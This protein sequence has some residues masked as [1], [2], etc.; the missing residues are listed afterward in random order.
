MKL[1]TAREYRMTARADAAARTGERILEAA[2]ELFWEAPTT[3]ISLAAVAA[4]AGGAARTG[5]RRSGC[6]ARKQKRR[7]PLCSRWRCGWRR[8]RGCRCWTWM[9]ARVR[10]ESWLYWI[11]IDSVSF[12]LYAAQRLSFVALLYLAYLLIAAFGWF[13]WRSRLRRQLAPGR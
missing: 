10:L 8:G 3:D 11:V 2:L 1:D 6:W 12:Y 4:R 13:E 5:S 9:T 7:S